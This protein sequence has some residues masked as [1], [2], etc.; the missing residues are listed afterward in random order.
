M[1]DY[2]DSIALMSTT[3][4]SSKDKPLRDIQYG[5]ARHLRDPDNAPAP[6]DVE[7]RR[8]QIYRDLFYRNV[9]SFIA[10]SFPV[11]REITDDESWHEM[12][13]DY[14]NNHQAHTPLFP[15]MPQEFLQYL[16]NEREADDDYPFISELAHYEWV[17]LALSLDTREI[18]MTGID[19]N[20]DLLDGVPLLSHLA[21]ALSYEFAV[22][23]ISPDYLPSV[24][25]KQNSYLIVY[26]NKA[27][28]VGFMELNPV[29]AR[30]VE[31]MQEDK[32]QTG[33]ELLLSIAQ[34]LQ[35]ADSN[36]VINGG[37]EILK[38]LHEKDIVLGTSTA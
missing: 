5:F 4:I 11:L 22:H 6:N 31:L 9:E 8:M 20:G 36:V 33:R 34:E 15:K 35:H 25:E 37:L 32:N 2:R 18:D 38:A 27:D 17:E 21:W 10:K 16:Q 30:L 13:R 14:F 23:R 29:S 3:N 19:E 1:N 26:R 7:D 28:E 24:A 12:L